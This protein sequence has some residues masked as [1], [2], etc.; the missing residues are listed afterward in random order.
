MPTSPLALAS[1]E[2]TMMVAARGWE[3]WILMLA[4]CWRIL[5]LKKDNKEQ[6]IKKKPKKT[7]SLSQKYNIKWSIIFLCFPP[8]INISFLYDILEKT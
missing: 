5:L 4:D 6:H 7:S 3:P 1:G 8:N 2:E